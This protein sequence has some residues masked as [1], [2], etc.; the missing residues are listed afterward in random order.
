[1][2]FPDTSG[3]PGNISHTIGNKTWN[4]DGEKWILQSVKVGAPSFAA[5]DPV[6]VANNAT[7]TTYSLDAATL[8]A[9]TAEET[10]NTTFTTSSSTEGTSSSTGT[11]GGSY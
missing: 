11:S 1:M 4:W 2:T 9:L 3:D 6:Q 7:T 10:E 8:D 5:V